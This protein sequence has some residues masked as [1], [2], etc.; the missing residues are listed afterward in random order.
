MPSRLNENHGAAR[1]Q[2]RAQHVCKPLEKSC[3]NRKAVRLFTVFERI[4]NNYQIR[5]TSGYC[6]SPPG[7]VQSAAFGCM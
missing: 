4:I 6:P 7:R 2:A 1:L 3:A 5:P